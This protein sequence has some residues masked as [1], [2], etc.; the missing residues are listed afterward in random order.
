MG[1]MLSDESEQFG[2]GS[3]GLGSGDTVTVEVT[4]IP[5][6]SDLGSGGVGLA[7]KGVA[8]NTKQV[9]ADV[10]PAVKAD[11]QELKFMTEDYVIE[12]PLKAVGIAAGVGFVL[13]V[14]WCR[15]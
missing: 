8:G 1:T 5:V 4:E 15:R 12:H 2:V 11:A 13:G 14:L 10:G 3:T 9:L 6:G 7:G